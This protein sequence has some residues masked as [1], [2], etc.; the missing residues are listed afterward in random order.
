MYIACNFVPMARLICIVSDVKFA[1]G[2]IPDTTVSLGFF[3][4]AME[5][6]VNF[7]HHAT[8]GTKSW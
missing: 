6:K 3:E 1:T 7:I 4:V 8:H 2:L 5:G